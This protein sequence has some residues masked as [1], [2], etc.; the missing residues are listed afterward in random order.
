[1]QKYICKIL[2][3]NWN[4]FIQRW[5]EGLIACHKMIDPY[6]EAKWKQKNAKF[7]SRFCRPLRSSFSAGKHYWMTVVNIKE[8]SKVHLFVHFSSGEDFND[9]SKHKQKLKACV[10]LMILKTRIS[11]PKSWDAQ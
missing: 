3:S 4:G 8:S 7:H 5:S 1:M 2:L 11:V 9:K 10:V 6:K